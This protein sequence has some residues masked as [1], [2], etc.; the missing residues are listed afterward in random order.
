MLIFG[1]RLLRSIFRNG[2]G[3]FFLDFFFFLIA[4]PS[5]CRGA[6]W[7]E[8]NQK[9]KTY[10]PTSKITSSFWLQMKLRKTKQKTPPQQNRTN[11]KKIQT[12]KPQTNNVCKVCEHMCGFKGYLFFSLFVF[13]MG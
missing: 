5:A 2:A 12:T 3:F 7:G 1:S 11:T 13:S 4:P 9:N 10:H 8:N 6:E